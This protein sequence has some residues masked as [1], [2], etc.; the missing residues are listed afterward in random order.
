MS[1]GILKYY[2]VPINEHND[3]VL[4]RLVKYLFQKME[5][6]IRKTGKI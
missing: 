2:N 5:K 3:E 1:V 4:A 6:I